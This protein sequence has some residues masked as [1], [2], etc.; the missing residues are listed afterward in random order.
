MSYTVV[1]QSG[2]IA[3]A[4]ADLGGAEGAQAWGLG[5]SSNPLKP[6]RE[7]RKSAAIQWPS[8]LPQLDVP[9]SSPGRRVLLR[10]SSVKIVTL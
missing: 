4:A 7:V 2:S 6:R 10:A 9:V 8:Y 1:C 5:C 3:V